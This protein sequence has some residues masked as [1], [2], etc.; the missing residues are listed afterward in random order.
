MRDTPLPERVEA[1]DTEYWG[2]PGKGGAFH[3]LFQ[4][5]QALSAGVCARMGRQDVDRF[6]VERDV[7]QAHADVLETVALEP[8]RQWEETG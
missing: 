6:T 3:A 8:V 4:A 2:T 5:T 7:I 1:V